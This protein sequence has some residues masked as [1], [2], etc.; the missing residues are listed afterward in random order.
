MAKWTNWFLYKYDQ[1]VR[2]HPSSHS[3]SLH[4]KGGGKAS[5]EG[6]G[7]GQN[8]GRR[9]DGAGFPPSLPHASLTLNGP[10]SPL[11]PGVWISIPPLPPQLQRGSVSLQPPM[12]C[13]SC[14]AHLPN[15]DHQYHFFTR[16]TNPA[17]LDGK[18]IQKDKLKDTKM[19]QLLNLLKQQNQR[20]HQ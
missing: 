5:S 19:Y 6:A 8:Q 14:P 9:V 2:P 10:T 11:H 16:E 18:P 17:F 1:K 7:G 20:E 3:P 13:V 12:T 15:G 4:P